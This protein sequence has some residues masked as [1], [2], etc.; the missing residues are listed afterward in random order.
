MFKTDIMVRARERALSLGVTNV[1]VATN[2]GASVLAALKAFGPT[3]AFFAVGN[4][5]SSHECGLCLHKGISEKTKTE[6]ESQG[7]RV[8]LR[9][10]T[11]FQGEPKCDAAVAQHRLVAR[12]YARRFHHKNHLPAGSEN[13]VSIMFNV[14]NELLGDGPRVCLEIALAAADSGL[15]P[16]DVDCMAIA[17]PSSYCDLPDAALTLRPVKSGEIFS[18][19]FRVKDILLCPTANDVWFSNGP[20]P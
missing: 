8:V 14:L 13:L 4:P 3:Y 7:I 19:Q 9:G 17:T 18:M 15:L 1:V 12:G 6:L 20:L 11:L 2:T 10:Q 5:A 16:L